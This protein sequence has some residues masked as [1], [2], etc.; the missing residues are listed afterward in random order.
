MNSA[1]R[2]AADPTRGDLRE[3]RVATQLTDVAGLRTPNT[4]KVIVIDTRDRGFPLTRVHYTAAGSGS[5]NGSNWLHNS[6]RSAPAKPI[7]SGQ[8]GLEMLRPTVSPDSLIGQ[9][10]SGEN[11]LRFGVG[12]VDATQ[13][14]DRDHSRRI[15]SRD[16]LP[17][18]ILRMR[19]P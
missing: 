4:Y 11:K 15:T 5:G 1:P 13:H 8:T 16:G 6:C 7:T 3:I 17:P 19:P 12:A 9:Q 2:A 14:L 18:Q 10:G